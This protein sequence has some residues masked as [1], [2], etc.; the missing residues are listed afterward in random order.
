MTS[1]FPE[2]PQQVAV[3]DFVDEVAQAGSPFLGIS[4]SDGRTVTVDLLP[5]SLVHM[6]QSS[7]GTHGVWARAGDVATVTVRFGEPVV[8]VAAVLSGRAAV[9]TS[10]NDTAW[11]VNGT[12]SGTDQDGP[13]QVQLQATDRSGN[14][15][16]FSALN[17]TGSLVTV[18]T[19]PPLFLSVSLASSNVNPGLAVYGDTATVFLRGSEP[20]GALPSVSIGSSIAT[21]EGALNISAH[22]QLLAPQT[23]GVL[24]FVVANYSDIAGNPG[25]ALNSTT[26]GSEVVL[27][28][29][30]DQTDAHDCSSH[31]SLQIPP[32]LQ[33]SRFVSN[34]SL[35][36]TRVG[37]G[38]SVQV[39][40]LFREPLQVPLISLC[41]HC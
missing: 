6:T 3:F 40:L 21:V 35:S 39:F 16:T 20:L 27:D 11:S 15:A 18:D 31:C 32:I 10:I 17:T 1:A 24:T 41:V 5:P 23:G 22:V 2:G 8:S 7:T 28:T 26:D 33:H 19:T 29:V 13:L 36:L 9:V 37:R 30:R 4:G 38:H 14:Q 34:G 12:I 25:R